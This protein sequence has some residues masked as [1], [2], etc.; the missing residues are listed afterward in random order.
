MNSKGISRSENMRRIR[1]KNTGP[2][3]A[4]RGLLRALG[5][6]G[7][8]LHRKDLPGRPDVAFVGRRKAILIHGCFWHGH[9]CKVGLREPKSNRDYWLPKIE[10][11]RRRDAAHMVELARLGWSVLT[12]W[13]CELRD[14]ETLE[15]RLTSFL[16]V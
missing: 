8:R 10:R 5:F 11:N 16:S 12:V 9:D 14:L 6:T 2:E 7:Y 1:G 3:L 15:A 13:E 4:V